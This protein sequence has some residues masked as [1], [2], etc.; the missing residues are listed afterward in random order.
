MENGRAYFRVENGEIFYNCDK[1]QVPVIIQYWL[2]TSKFIF[3]CEAFR[4]V[5]FSYSDFTVEVRFT[6]V[7][8]Y[9]YSVIWKSKN[10]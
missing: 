8:R 7:G 5:R 9:N 1:T 10:I 3:C 2:Y 4:F 6:P